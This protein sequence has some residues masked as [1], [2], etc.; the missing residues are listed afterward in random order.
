MECENARYRSLSEAAFEGIVIHDGARII[1]INQTMTTLFGYAPE[2]LIGYPFEMFIAPD[3]LSDFHQQQT[4]YKPFEIDL[5][6]K[7][8]SRFP[9]VIQTRP[10]LW[11]DHP[12]FVTAIHDITWRRELEQENLALKATL[13]DR[14]K[15][16]A[17]IGKSP[18]MQAL[19]E[20]IAHAAA[21][22]ANVLISGETGSGKELAAQT[23]HNQSQRQQSP[24]V[25]VNCASI[26]AS[27]FEREFFGHRKGAFTG[28]DRDAP[29]F[30]DAAHK[31]T[32]FLDEIGE[33]SQ[34]MQAVLLRAIERHEYTPVG[35][36]SPKHANIR[37]IAATNRQ[38]P[39]LVKQGQIR[40]DFF[41]RL[42]VLTIHI[43]PLRERK[44]DIPLLIDHFF[45][46]HWQGATRPNVPMKIVEMLRQYDW[47]GNVRELFNEL[48][49]FAVTHHLTLPSIRQ[50][51]PDAGNTEE[52]PDLPLELAV[53]QFEKQF[54]LHT[55]QRYQWQKAR[56]AEKLGIN[57]KTLYQKMKKY[58]LLGE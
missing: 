54:I 17:M 49:R 46:R 7:D 53:E 18:V 22:D 19:Y 57:R 52:P 37:I 4:A 12:L 9:A 13:H 3:V 56:T 11:Q 41:Y 36:N 55:L 23:I 10:F 45:E 14:Y 31:G 33:L 30:F 39:A 44:E 24:F 48:Q 38:L 43:P 34:T 8:R 50:L 2:E 27:V 28:A 42:S 20:I 32:L 16:G 15:F 40:E 51:A 5:M 35:S 26:A 47:P 25:V 1:E 58:G 6:R 21:S 29:G